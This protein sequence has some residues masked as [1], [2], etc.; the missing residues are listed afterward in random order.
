MTFIRP[1]CVL[2]LL[3]AMWPLAAGAAVPIAPEPSP[4]PEPLLEAAPT[5]PNTGRLVVAWTKVAQALARKDVGE[6]QRLAFMVSAA[7]WR[8]ALTPGQST[9]LETATALTLLPESMG[10]HVWLPYLG[11]WILNAKPDHAN[12]AQQAMLVTGALMDL[13]DPSALH[14]WEVAESTIADLC[15]ALLWVAGT[16]KRPLLSRLTA[17][18][19]L[20]RSRG[21]CPLPA[22]D[23]AAD[24]QPAIRRAVVAVLPATGVGLPVLQ[25]RLEDDVPA[26]ASAA[27]AR[28][29]QG[30]GTGPPDALALRLARQFAVAPATPEDSV[31]MLDCLAR[32]PEPEDR[33]LLERL[34]RN[35]PPALRQRAKEILSSSR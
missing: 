31:E 26:V 12:L 16:P 15:A 29:C 35:A 34:A 32:S 7:D 2:A 1:A 9:K 17:L 23:L 13:R 24:P 27:A 30:P 3:V 10:A 11:L 4:Q 6:A 20:A 28:L 8:A 19:A 33:K 22:L 25:A 18:E 5:N 21:A 14:E